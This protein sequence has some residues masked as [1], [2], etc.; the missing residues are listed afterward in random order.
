MTV[1]LNLGLSRTVKLGKTPWKFALEAN[2]YIEH[3]DRLGPESMIGFN[4]SPLVPNIFAQ[5][6]G[7]T[8]FA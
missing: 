3:S 6:L 2:Y 7:I 8:K 4:V 5:W 1:P